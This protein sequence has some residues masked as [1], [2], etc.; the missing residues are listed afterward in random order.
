MSYD[1]INND[2]YTRRSLTDEKFRVLLVTNG[3]YYLSIQNSTWLASSSGTFLRANN[4]RYSSVDKTLILNQTSSSSGNDTLG[5][6]QTLKFHY[7]LYN[8]PSTTVDYIIYTYDDYDMVR[9]S[10][11]KFKIFFKIDFLFLN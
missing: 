2:K 3:S 8:D 7:S 10:Q 4:F 11:V 6:Y 9:F 5:R 1:L